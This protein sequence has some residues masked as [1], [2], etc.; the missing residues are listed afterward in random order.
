MNKKS[1]MLIFDLETSGFSYKKNTICSISMKKHNEDKW[2]NIFIK[3]NSNYEYVD[4]AMEVNG[5]DLKWLEEH[6]MSDEQAIKEVYNFIKT[7]FDDNPLTLGHNSANF[8][9]P[10]L[11]AYFNRQN[12]SFKDL[13]S[14][15][16]MDTMILAKMLKDAE[17]IK[18]ESIGLSK[19][20]KSLFGKEFE[21]QHTSEADVL[22]TE[23]IYNKMVE[24]IKIK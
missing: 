10:F 16:Q 9:V 21:N 15:H 23:M 17:V 3:P 4:Q 13:V 12:Q 6:G 1:N 5:L 22:A 2:L 8:D 24:L 20:Y 19:V 7:N 11:E 14:Y 18:T